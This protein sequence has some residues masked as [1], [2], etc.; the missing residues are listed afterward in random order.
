METT[1]M[2]ICRW[3]GDKPKLNTN[4]CSEIVVEYHE[5][6]HECQSIRKSIK[7]EF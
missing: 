4:L 6:L 7:R 1:L 5:Y 2:I 3:N